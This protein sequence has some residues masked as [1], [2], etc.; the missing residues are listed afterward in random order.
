MCLRLLTTVKGDSIHQQDVQQ[1]GVAY[2]GM[3]VEDEVVVAEHNA[4]ANLAVS[5]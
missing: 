3:G 2:A 4:V 1:E 5:G